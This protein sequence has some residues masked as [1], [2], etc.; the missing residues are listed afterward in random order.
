MNGKG[1]EER[2][3]AVEIIERLKELKSKRTQ[4]LED[5]TLEELETIRGE[6]PEEYVQL[7]HRPEIDDSGF[8]RSKPLYREDFTERE[9][10]LMERLA[11]VEYKHLKSRG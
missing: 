1:P 3:P 7:Q 10:E 11:P 5:F 9:L 4:Y 2:S 8:Q 6:A